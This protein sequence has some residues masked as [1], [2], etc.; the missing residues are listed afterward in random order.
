[1]AHT[2]PNKEVVRRICLLHGAT[3]C[4]LFVET[5]NQFVQVLTN[6]DSDKITTCL[7]E[8]ESWCGMKFELF[9]MDSEKETIHIIE[10]KGEKILPI[11][12]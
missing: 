1:M 6:I 10:Q 3:D 2:T 7:S 5:G 12:I 8:L 11:V 4:Y 9:N